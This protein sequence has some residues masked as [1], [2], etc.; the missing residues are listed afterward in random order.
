M[1]VIEPSVLSSTR[2]ALVTVRPVLRTSSAVFPVIDQFEA[3]V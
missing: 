3:S 1:T 2:S